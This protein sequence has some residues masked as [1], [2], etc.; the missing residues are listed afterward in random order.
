MSNESVACPN[1]GRHLSRKVRSQRYLDIIGV[2]ECPKCKAVL[3][4]CYKGES[5][6]IVKPWMSDQ[7][8]PLDR[9][10]HYDLTVLGGDG[11]ER[12]HG[13]FDIETRL[14]VQVG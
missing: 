9:W 12:R 6:R 2:H 4:E 7:D 13:F 10:R 8:V 1:C 3:G 14:I 5:Y 11:I